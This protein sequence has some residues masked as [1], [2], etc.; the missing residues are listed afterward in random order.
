MASVMLNPLKYA[1]Y[2]VAAGAV[3]FVVSGCLIPS[4]RGVVNLVFAITAAYL[5]IVIVGGCLA[6]SSCRIGKLLECASLPIST[7]VV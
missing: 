5:T 1:R 2:L 4:V 3:A 6:G 7:S